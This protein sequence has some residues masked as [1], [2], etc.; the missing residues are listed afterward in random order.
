M[1][2]MSNKCEQRMKVFIN[3]YEIDKSLRPMRMN[4]INK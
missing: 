3:M 4:K 2:D 1:N